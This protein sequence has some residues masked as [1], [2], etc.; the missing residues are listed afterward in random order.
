MTTAT[1]S[2]TELLRSPNEVTGRV[3][4]GDVIIRRRDAE[5]LVLT[6]VA[7][8][9]ARSISVEVVTR[10]LAD[11]LEDDVVRRHI[12]KRVALP[13]LR[14]LPVVERE[15]FYRELFEC[16]IGSVE[17]GTMAPVAQLLADWQAT[18][19]VHADPAL[20]EHMRRPAV[21]EGAPVARPAGA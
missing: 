17:L 7:R 9:Q 1:A 11:A 8:D 13:W 14:F 19:A 12:A 20:A 21:A 16:V 5:D 15:A 4:G 18:A 2:F 10:L 6:T 3:A